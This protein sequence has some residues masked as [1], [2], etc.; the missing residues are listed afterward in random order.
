MSY[1]D[2][3]A[4]MND[5]YQRAQASGSDDLP[6]NGDYQCVVDRFDFI[7]AKSNG[8][9]YLKTMTTVANGAHKGWNI[10]FLHDLEDADRLKHLKTHLRTLG[11]P[12]D[13]LGALEGNL[14]KALDSVVEVSVYTPKGYDRSFAKVTRRHENVRSSDIPYDDTPAAPVTIKDGAGGD[15]I[16]F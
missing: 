2:R 14:P 3:L 7:E 11:V 10:S 9:L 6:P 1:Q 4:S 15:P 8:R 5:D 16:P 12:D 13:D